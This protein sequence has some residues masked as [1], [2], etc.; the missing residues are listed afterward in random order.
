MGALVVVEVILV[1]GCVE[2]VIRIGIP[3][4]VEG[5]PVGILVGGCVEVVIFL[6]PGSKGSV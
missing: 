1:G 2:V 4:V 5:I 6:I 3:I